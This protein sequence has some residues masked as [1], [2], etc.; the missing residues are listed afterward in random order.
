MQIGRP[1]RPKAAVAACEAGAE[2]LRRGRPIPANSQL[3]GEGEMRETGDWF[4]DD[5]FWEWTAP[6]LFSA[7]RWRHTPEQ[8]DRILALLDLPAGAHLLDLCCG[9]GRH[10]LELARRGFQVT[11][12]DRTARYLDRARKAARTEGL[13]VEFM[14][15][16][17]RCFRRPQAFDAAL[18][19]YT[20]FGYFSDPRDDRRVLENLRASLRAGGELLMEL[21]GK[22]V[23]ARG[24]RERDWVEYADGTKLL[25]QRV[26]DPDWSHVT[27]RWTIVRAD[28]QRS[29]RLRLRLYAAS[30]LRALLEASGFEQVR[31][32]GGLDGRPYDQD[33]R[34]LIACARTPEA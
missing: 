1:E 26:L 14:E 23:L 17:M 7:E 21:M 33:A 31:I 12:V 34:R 10:S 24:F 25:E 15:A 6:V 20:S 5:A 28:R 13:A 8:T 11:G 22:E 2:G 30:E 3:R 32:H 27:C 9:P 18:N 4:E 16:D 19:L 29:F